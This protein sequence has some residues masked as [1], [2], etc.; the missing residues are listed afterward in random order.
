VNLGFTLT[1]YWQ[2][3][4]IY[5]WTL[6][7]SNLDFI[8]SDDPCPATQYLGGAGSD[9]EVF[10][11]DDFGTLVTG[12]YL[13]ENIITVNLTVTGSVQVSTDNF[14]ASVNSDT[15]GAIFL[16]VGLEGH[17]NSTA[18]LWFTTLDDT[19]ESISC[20]ISLLGCPT[21]YAV[22]SGELYDTCVPQIDWGYLLSLILLSFSSLLLMILCFLILLLAGRH[23]R[24]V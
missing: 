16:Q 12:T 2:K 23:L 6:A 14:T 17:K 10:L 20:S 9:V 18:R 3:I 22:Q 24:F 19:I 21:G 1:L 5:Q 4:E 8:D 15:G 13:N 11:F 7:P